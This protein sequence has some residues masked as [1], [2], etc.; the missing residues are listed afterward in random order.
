MLL[1][2]INLLYFIFLQR[3]RR[4]KEKRLRGKPNLMLL[5]QPSSNRERG[6]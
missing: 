4:G 6:S 1:S 2:I 3:K 5:Q